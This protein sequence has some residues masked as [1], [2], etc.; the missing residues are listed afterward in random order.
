MID[1]S[2]ARAAKGRK[3]KYTTVSGTRPWLMNSPEIRLTG[4]VSSSSAEIKFVDQYGKEDVTWVGFG[5]LTL[6]NN[7]HQDTIDTLT[8]KRDDLQKQIDALNNAIKVLEEA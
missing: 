5:S 8:S 6:V 7:A 2:T 3:V 4:N 1:I